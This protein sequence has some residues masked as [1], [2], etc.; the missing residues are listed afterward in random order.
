[1]V[2]FECN[3]T[4][5]EVAST[6]R[7]EVLF[8]EFGQFSFVVA[9]HS[10]FEIWHVSW[11]LQE[12]FFCSLRHY[13]CYAQ[14]EQDRRRR[15]ATQKV[16]STLAPST[17]GNKQRSGGDGEWWFPFECNITISEVAST[18][19][20][21]VM[22]VDFGYFTF[23]VASHGMFLHTHTIWCAYP[24]GS[25]YFLWCLSSYDKAIN[26]SQSQRIESNQQSQT[27]NQNEP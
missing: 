26:R 27:K 5:S 10:R 1:M 21:E 18:N 3:G 20:F 14:E 24:S 23:V 7:S 6:N 4:I 17:H 13:E 2:S 9:S 19:R 25:V 8:V 15:E 12:L 16:E 11:C 22:L